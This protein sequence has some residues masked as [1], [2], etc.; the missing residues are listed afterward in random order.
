MNGVGEKISIVFLLLTVMNISSSPYPFLLLLCYAVHEVG[1][2]LFAKLVGAG[3]KD[4]KA[5]LF[6]LNLRYD[7][8]S[9]TYLREALVCG[10]GIIFNL[11]FF[12]IFANPVFDFN[13][14][15]Y[16]FALYNLSLGL[17]NLYPVSVLDG[18][19]VMRC[20]IYRFSR[21]D[22]AQRIN[23]CL[24][25]VFAFFLWLISVYLQLVFAS[26]VSLFFISVFLL[27]SLCFRA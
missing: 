10:G 12:V 4:F 7:C 26:D 19:E 25:F 21:V 8:A 16:Y 1:H 17:M 15:F 6:R 27:Y 2:L 20:L 3:I 22:R 14:K 24:S 13:D 5:S 9:L 23:R 11:V 18:G